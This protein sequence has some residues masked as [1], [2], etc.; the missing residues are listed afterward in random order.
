MEK[1]R[2][3]VFAS[4]NGSNAEAIMKYFQN[5]PKIEVAGLLSNN[6]EAYALERAKKFQVPTKVLDKNQFRECD[7][8]LKWLNTNKITHIVLAGFLLLIPEKLINAFPDR[9][10]NI[11]PSLL[12]KFGG[13]G[14]YGMKVHEAVVT[15]GEKETGITIHLVNAHYDD[16]KILAQIKCSVL[17]ADNAKSIAERVLQLEHEDYPK[18]IE[19]WASPAPSP[20]PWERGV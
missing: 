7:E 4:G 2:L 16:G 3:A 6:P 20:L 12:P 1:I 18:V 14:M 10:I 11:H 19:Q 5:H 15:A 9:I 13:K 8:V 17:P